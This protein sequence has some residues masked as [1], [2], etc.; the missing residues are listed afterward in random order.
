MRFV[1]IMFDNKDFVGMT[2]STHQDP[3]IALH[4]PAALAQRPDGI[5]I[6]PFKRL[7]D[8]VNAPIMFPLGA[9][10]MMDLHPEGPTFKAYQRSM[11]DI[12]LPQKDIAKPRIIARMN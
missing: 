10:V 11:S 4:E 2:D 1:Q 6:M 5:G 9:C 7:P 8:F 3:F 12:V